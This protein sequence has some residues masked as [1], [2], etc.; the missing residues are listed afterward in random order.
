M[1]IPPEDIPDSIEYLNDM[2][3]VHREW[4]TRSVNAVCIKITPFDLRQFPDFEGIEK[5]YLHYEKE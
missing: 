4:D 1:W 3:V 2:V 5:I